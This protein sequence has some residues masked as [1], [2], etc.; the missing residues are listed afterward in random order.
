MRRLNTKS[1]IIR[2]EFIIEANNLIKIIDSIILFLNNPPKSSDT[3]EILQQDFFKYVQ[4]V[5]DAIRKINM[6]TVTSFGAEVRKI[7][8]EY[9]SLV[10]RELTF[11]EKTT[12]LQKDKLRKF[13]KMIETAILFIQDTLNVDKEATKQLNLNRYETMIKKKYGLS[14]ED[15]LNI[16]TKQNN[17]CAICGREPK[18]GKKLVLDHN[19]KTGKVRGMLCD[20]CNMLVGMRENNNNLFEKTDK[21]IK[22]H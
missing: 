15:Y 6:I 13:K 1:R 14:V 8:V 17:R 11:K 7:A 16:V 3:M 5:D 22:E 9:L 20:L 12:E 4:K 21:Y 18:W 10:F 2:E 19:H